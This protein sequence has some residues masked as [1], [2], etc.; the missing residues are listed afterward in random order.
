MLNKSKSQMY[1]WVDI[2][3]NPIRGKC[4]HACTY[5]YVPHSRVKHLYQ[6]EPHLV[7]SFFEKGLG[8][9]KMIFIGSCFDIFAEPILM[10]WIERIF[11]RCV[12][13]DNTCLFQTKNP[14]RFY[15]LRKIGLP[16]NA[17]YGT[18]IETTDGLLSKR[19]SRAPDVYIRFAD[20]AEANVPAKMISIE[21]IMDFDLSRMIN[22]MKEIK[23][24]FIS[25]GADSKNCG[26]PEPDGNKIKELIIELK[27][28]TEVRLKTNLKRLLKDGL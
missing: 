4:P 20:I 26:L 5:C 25:I 10:Q 17:I 18:T 11:N 2:T 8:S 13:F 14:G 27:K 6:G 22:W 21:P 16:S 28:F 1:P 15:E 12:R 19:V 24:L 23:P 3:K 9:G 7:E